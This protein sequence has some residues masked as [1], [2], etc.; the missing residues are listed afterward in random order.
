LN[1][2]AS[3]TVEKFDRATRDLA[4]RRQI[5]YVPALSDQLTGLVLDQLFD[6][7]RRLPPR[8][9][10]MALLREPTQQERQELITAARPRGHLLAEVPRLEEVDRLLEQYRAELARLKIVTQR[11]DLLLEVP[12]IIAGGYRFLKQSLGGQTPDLP[13][14]L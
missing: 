4:R 2:A 1:T 5:E 14:R 6:H 3:V 8:D 7:V 10:Q 12:S 9:G 11:D 13:Q